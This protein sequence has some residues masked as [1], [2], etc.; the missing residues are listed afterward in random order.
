[1]DIY[2][3]MC[4]QGFP[5]DSVIKNLPAS[6]RHRDST[7]GLEDPLEKG[8]AT[9]FLPGKSQGQRSLVGYGPWGHKSGTSLSN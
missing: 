4:V 7:S 3:C 9:N 5:G 2:V 8:M 1:M 6:A